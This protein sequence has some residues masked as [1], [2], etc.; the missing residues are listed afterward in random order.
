M[1]DLLVKLQATLIP[2]NIAGLG[3]ISSTPGNA[4]IR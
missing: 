4:L 2:S 1:M 3:G